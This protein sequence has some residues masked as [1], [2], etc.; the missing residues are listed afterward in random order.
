MYLLDFSCVKDC[1]KCCIERE[2]YPTTRYGKIGVLVMPDEK[3][4]IEYLAKKH[5]VKVTIL[6]RIGISEKNDKPEKILAY[7]LMGKDPNGNTCPFLDTESDKRS[8]HG[9]FVCKIYDDRPL[10]CRAYPLIGSSPPSMDPKCK[11][12]EICSSADGNIQS[13]LESLAK[14]QAKMETSA[15]YVWRYAT[16]IGEPSD[17]E[18]IEVGWS[19]I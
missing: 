19:L 8:P 9:G 17:K 6:P 13:E 4:K 1:S 10:A 12:C 18:K 7:Q 15:R 2:Y 5:A 3:E 16:G 11:F 14:I